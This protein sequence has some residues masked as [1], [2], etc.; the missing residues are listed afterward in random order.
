MRFEI[1]TNF[2]LFALLMFLFIAPQSF[3]ASD[4][5]FYLNEKNYMP[6]VKLE[7]LG[8]ISDG[9]RS[10][11]AMYALQNGAGCAG[12]NESIS[13]LLT[14]SLNV[15]GQCSKEHIELIRT[16]FKNSIPQMSNYADSIY[17]K[18]QNPDDLENI[19]YRMPDSATFQHKWDIIR[20]SQKGS[21]V[22]VDAHGTFLER[23]ETGSY[24]YIT[25]YKIEK[26]LVVVISHK[27]VPTGKK[28]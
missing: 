21:T 7:R 2:I 5:I 24:R 8:P 28:K 20:V 9:M 6:V 16:W 23:E 25:E 17:N 3:A 27:K 26:N 19:C 22:K 12:G 14:D 11:L 10:I 15:G 1:K 13:C 18:I 4:V